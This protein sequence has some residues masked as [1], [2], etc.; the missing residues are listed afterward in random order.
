MMR[1]CS[2][3]VFFLLVSGILAL[4]EGQCDPVPIRLFQNGVNLG[5]VGPVSTAQNVED[6]YGYKH[7]SFTGPLPIAERRSLVTIH[8][9]ST[10]CELSFVI[11]HGKPYADDIYMA[12]QMYINGD[13]HD[14]L[15]KDDPMFT[16]LVLHGTDVVFVDSFVPHSATT[17]LVKI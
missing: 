10:T 12:A 16:D 11:V 4:V 15:V 6:F 3:D 5:T 8:Q 1:L 7:K 9:D 17:S 14:P 13:L 2:I